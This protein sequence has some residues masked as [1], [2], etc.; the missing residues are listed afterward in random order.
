[1]LLTIC[2]STTEHITAWHTAISKHSF[3]V[4]RGI[5]KGRQI[6]IF[7][8]E[9]KCQERRILAIN[10]YQNGT[11]MVQ[12]NE[13]A[14][15]SFVQ[16]FLTLKKTAASKKDTG[17]TLSS[18][19]TIRTTRLAMLEVELTELREQLLSTSTT[20]HPDL[21][22]QLS[23]YKHQMDTTTQELREQ[24]SNLQ[25]DKQALATELRETKDIM[26]REI[27]QMRDE[28]MR[29]LSA[30]MVE[31]QLQHRTQTV[32]MPPSLPTTE[33]PPLS[34][35]TTEGRPP[36]PCPPSPSGTSK[37]Q[38]STLKK[39][40]EVA[41]LIDSNGKFIQE[42]KLF[43]NMKVSKIWC[44]TTEAA[45]QILSHPEFG[46]PGH[47]LIHTG[48][49]NLREEQEKVGSLVTKVAEEAATSFPNSHIT[50]STLLPRRDFHPR[51]I[52]RV[53]R[54]ITRGCASLPNV[55]VAHHP[56]ITPEHLFV[57]SHLKKQAVGIFTK[58][59]KD[60]ALG[61]QS[62]HLTPT[63]GAARG[64][65][66]EPHYAPDPIWSQRPPRHPPRPGTRAA[67]FWKKSLP[68]THHRPPPPPYHHFQ[69][70]RQT[71]PDSGYYPTPNQ[72]V[73]QNQEPTPSHSHSRQSHTKLHAATQRRSKDEWTEKG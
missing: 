44:P 30:V 42:Q 23:Q 33:P 3:Y 40:T 70:Q 57:H 7:E 15:G 37:R 64:P 49:N 39:D 19:T 62:L 12:G 71:G 20:T 56:A 9:D 38:T 25:K 45:L 18:P 26:R 46:T 6:Q 51:T 14:L 61:R 1:M 2:C 10:F 58:S 67:R 53:N 31:L 66:R 54:D 60:V 41:I 21:Q 43:P 50:I 28:M 59:L 55:H 48:T 36:A 65:S 13:A 11:V 17:S 22:E 52:H 16:S 47:I 27:A 32:E 34:E 69:Q 24:I 68:G 5:C 29:E 8:D 73:Y 4:K 35:D 72:R 63:R